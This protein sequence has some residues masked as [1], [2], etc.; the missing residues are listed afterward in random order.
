MKRIACVVLLV[1]L[2]VTLIACSPYSWNNA[3]KDIEKLTSEGFVVFNKDIQETINIATEALNKQIERDGYDF[4][5]RLK[6]ITSL[7]ESVSSTVSFFEFATEKQAKQFYEYYMEIETD[8]KFV[9]FGK[10]IIRTNSAS[11]AD[12]LG[13]D[14]N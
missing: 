14:F 9:R 4:T 6:H 10:I 2:A 13:Y 8:Y 12:L 1:V 11:A 5:I 3:L 7:S